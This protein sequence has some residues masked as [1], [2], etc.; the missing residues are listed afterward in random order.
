[1]RAALALLLLV[2]CGDVSDL[3]TSGGASEPTTLSE[4][5]FRPK[6]GPVVESA[7]ARITELGDG[8]VL[9]LPTGDTEHGIR[10]S[11]GDDASNAGYVVVSAMAD[12]AF[13]LELVMGG[14]SLGVRTSGS[15][16]RRW[17]EFTFGAGKPLSELGTDDVHLRWRDVESPVAIDRL[18][19]VR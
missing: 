3:P 8:H 10:I 2:A 15:T 9:M 16:Q 7:G 5:T 17:K 1:M 11:I 19:F 6:A 4:L 18:R 13:T 14:K 12:G